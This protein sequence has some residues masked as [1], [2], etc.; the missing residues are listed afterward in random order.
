MRG[1]NRRIKT[2][3]DARPIPLISITCKPYYYDNKVALLGDAAY[4]TAPFYGDAV[5]NC[6]LEDC[7]VLEEPLDKYS[8][9][10][11]HFS[12]VKGCFIGILGNYSDLRCPTGHSLTELAMSNYTEMK[13]L[14]RFGLSPIQCIPTDNL[15]YKWFPS[16]WMPF[17]TTITFTYEPI[18]E[19]VKRKE[20]QDRFLKKVWVFV[21]IA[22]GTILIRR[23]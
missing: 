11:N 9:N 14:G 1:F 7:L 22:L 16:R 18:H 13:F 10:F 21:V 8:R 17:S 15:L 4:V 12:M 6:G 23:L 3:S 19:C 2:L 5:W 20:G